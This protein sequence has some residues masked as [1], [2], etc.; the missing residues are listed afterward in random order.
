MSSRIKPTLTQQPGGPVLA[1]CSSDCPGL[2]KEDRWGTAPS[3]H[4]GPEQEHRH[5][6]RM[7]FVKPGISPC[8][9][10]RREQDAEAKAGSLAAHRGGDE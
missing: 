8:E 3:Y 7:V 5:W 9:P 6:H 10:W 2:E 4:C 1:T